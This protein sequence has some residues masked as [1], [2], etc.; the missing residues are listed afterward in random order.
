MEAS[1]KSKIKSMAKDMGF[2]EVEENQAYLS[3][4]SVLITDESDNREKAQ[5]LL[6]KIKLQEQQMQEQGYQ[7]HL[8]AIDPRTCK[9]VWDLPA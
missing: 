7:K 1:T 6:Y 5:L 9:E 3:A 2:A 4:S 8:E